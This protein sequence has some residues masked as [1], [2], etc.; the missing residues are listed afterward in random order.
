MESLFEPILD[1]DEKIIKV[2]KPNKTKLF[3]SSILQS[4]YI[5]FIMCV[6]P[7]IALSVNGLFVFLII[8][9]IALS[10][11][12]FLALL[13]TNIYYNNLYFTYTN[14]RII[15]RSG[16]FGI[17]Y[18]SLDM[19]MIGAIN[20]SVSLIDKILNKNT[21]TISFGSTASPINAYGNTSGVSSYK[22]S[23]IT[24][25]YDFYREIKT[26]IDGYKI[27]KK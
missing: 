24:A 11:G 1:S 5:L 26:I 7:I 23:H 14:K 27:A 4:L 10:L 20:V 19:G 15:I 22:F 25:P 16:I 2:V 8:P 9:F 17:D 13:L 3:L 21:G 18:K 12:I 6:T